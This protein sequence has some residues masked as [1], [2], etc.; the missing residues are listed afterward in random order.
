MAR[1]PSLAISSQRP[2]ILTRATSAVNSAKERR[3]N[4]TPTP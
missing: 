3:K 2:A 4:E 1:R